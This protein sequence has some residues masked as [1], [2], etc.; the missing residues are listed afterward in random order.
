MVGSAVAVRARQLCKVRWEREGLNRT[1]SGSF[2]P[3]KPGIYQGPNI[4]EQTASVA[5]VVAGS[6]AWEPEGGRGRIQMCCS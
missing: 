6:R 4:Q 2:C 5:K 3:H 1:L